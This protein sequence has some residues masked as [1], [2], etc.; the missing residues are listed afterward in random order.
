MQRFFTFLEL[1]LLLVFHIAQQEDE[2]AAFAGLQFYFQ[3]VR[4]DGTPT[5]GNAVARSAFYYPFR[6]GKLV[7]ESHK[8]F[9]VSIETVY[10][11]IDTVE[12]VVIAAFLVFRLV[13]DDRPVHFHL[14]RGEVTLEVLHVRSGIPQAPF[15]KG[16]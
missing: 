10:G 4:G 12:G 14:S 6:V 5:V 3:I 13:V 9:A 7:V 8:C 15:G 11:C 16:E 2:V 1:C